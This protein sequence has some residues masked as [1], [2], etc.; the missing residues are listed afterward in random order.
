VTLLLLIQVPYATPQSEPL[1]LL[2]C[3]DLRSS[4]NAR[5]K[6]PRGLR[7]ISGLAVTDHDTLLAHNDEELVIVEMTPTGKFLR[8]RS[9]T[10]TGFQLDFEGIAVVN[11]RVNLISSQGVIVSANFPFDKQ[12]F[13]QW[14][15]SL[16][17]ICEIEGLDFWIEAQ[18]LIVLCKR[19]KR[20]N[21]KNEIRLLLLTR[22]ND[23]AVTRQISVALP[24]SDNEPVKAFTGSGV[25]HVPGLDHFLVLSSRTRAIAEL[26]VKGDL[27]KIKRLKK[28]Q[29]RQPEGI[30]LTANG[31]LI[32]ANEGRSKSG[33]LV[34]HKQLPGCLQRHLF[35]ASQPR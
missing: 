23:A 6:L 5:I 18:T 33:Y 3:Y 26:T 1:S 28:K 14:H 12:P 4:D 29:H 19:I 9:D 7:E 8:V 17:G 27:V 15:S 20:D 11:N 32:I 35:A 30:E 25:V 22:D 34:V 10:R 24:E 21:S 16:A 31:E 2:D 13:T